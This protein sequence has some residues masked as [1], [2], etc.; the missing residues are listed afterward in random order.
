MVGSSEQKAAAT[1][2]W[3]GCAGCVGWEDQMLGE[4]GPVGCRAL[5]LGGELSFCSVWREMLFGQVLFLASQL[6]KMPR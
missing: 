2:C 1:T 5:V 6:L 3:M 4:G